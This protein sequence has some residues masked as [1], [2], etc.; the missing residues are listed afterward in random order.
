MSEDSLDD[1]LDDMFHGCAWSA[2]LELAA[3]SGRIPDA[4]ATRRLAYRYYEEALADKNCASSS[5]LDS[6]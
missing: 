6:G 1:L 4:E 5:S 2:F 3:S